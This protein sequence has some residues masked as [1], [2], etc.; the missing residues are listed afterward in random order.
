MFNAFVLMTQDD[1]LLKVWFK[2][3]DTFLLPKAC[4]LFEIT[5]YLVHGFVFV[6]SALTNHSGMIS[7]AWHWLSAS[8]L[9]SNWFIP[10]LVFVLIGQIRCLWTISVR[11]LC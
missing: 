5:R 6:Q 3:D 10:L 7:P 2:Q 9:S 11:K 1:S 4:L 8:V